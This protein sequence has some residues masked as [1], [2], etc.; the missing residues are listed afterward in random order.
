MVLQVEPVSPDRITESSTMVRN[1]CVEL[2][3]VGEGLERGVSVDVNFIPQGYS[4]A[5]KLTL[6][7]VGYTYG[8]L[9]VIQ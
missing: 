4:Q 1:L 7:H 3:S 8:Q 5:S 9:S 2:V 6:Y